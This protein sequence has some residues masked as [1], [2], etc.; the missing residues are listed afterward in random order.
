MKRE[1]LKSI[2]P[3]I[4]EEQIDAVLNLRSSEIERTNKEIE[5]L[6][7]QIEAKGNEIDRYKTTVAELEK[8]NGDSE[9]LNRRIQELQATIEEH[10]EAD[11]Q[12]AAEKALNDRFGAVLGENEFINDFT[13]N[14]IYSEFRTALEAEGNKGKSDADIYAAIV[15]DRDGIFKNPNPITTTGGSGGGDPSVIEDDQIRAV[16]GLP[17][18]KQ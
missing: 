17:P 6:K 18:K 4:T 13:Y 5:D 16:M 1:N 14:G 12:A 8:A 15:K 7:T 10:E 2:I 3:D 11:R 9:E